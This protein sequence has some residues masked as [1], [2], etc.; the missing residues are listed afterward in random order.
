MEGRLQNDSKQHALHCGFPMSHLGL[1]YT[2]FTLTE[3]INA[4]PPQGLPLWR[5]AIQEQ[6]KQSNK[7]TTGL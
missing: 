7:P 6:E 2:D 3:V 4:V 1:P 5:K